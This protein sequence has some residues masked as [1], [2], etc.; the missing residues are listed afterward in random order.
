MGRSSMFRRAVFAIL[1]LSLFAVAAQAPD[2][3]VT[4]NNNYDPWVF[5]SYGLKVSSVTN[6]QRVIV[7]KDGIWGVDDQNRV[8]FQLFVDGSLHLF[9]EERRETVTI[10]GLNG[11]VLVNGRPI[12][13]CK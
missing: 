2:A 8:R 9:N 4:A 12:G 7:L 6:Q 10:D 5:N 13:E 11:Q 1:A 3:I